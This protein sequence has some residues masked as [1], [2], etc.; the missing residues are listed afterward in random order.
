MY[1]RHIITSVMFMLCVVVFFGII[2]PAIVTGVGAVVFP[3][4]ADGSFVKRDGVVVGSSLIGQ[5]FLNK[6][7][8]PDPRFFQPRPSAADYDSESSE[9][10][11][12]G[13]SDPREVGFIAGFNTLDLNGNPSPTNVF[14]TKA[15]P[16]C[17][18]MDA[19]SGDPVYGP[20]ITTGDK[21]AKNPD[22]SYQC[23][24][25]TVPERVIAYRQMYNLP[26]SVK[27][28]I[29]AVTASA[30]GLDPDI[31][32]ANALLQAPAVAAANHLPA[33]EVIALVKRHENGYQWGFLGEKTV[34]VLDLNLALQNLKA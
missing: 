32:I 34:N 15:D 24:P 30:S 1:R 25:N 28:P 13:P 7:G 22:G 26:A 31:S 23:D 12:L 14:A 20:P 17:V 2:Y 19:T 27:V 33:A 6:Q 4:R 18:P 8:N 5:N 9:A 3:W 11:N 29:D 10:S 16:F 21:Y